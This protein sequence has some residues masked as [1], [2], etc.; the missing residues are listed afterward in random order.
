MSFPLKNGGNMLLNHGPFVLFS[1]FSLFLV[2][3][4]TFDSRAEIIKNENSNAEIVFEGN[5]ADKKG[6]CFNHLNQ[7]EVTALVRGEN[8]VKWLY[9]WGTRPSKE[10]EA[11]FKKQGILFVPMQWGLS[12]PKS[13]SEL[14][15]YYKNHP[16]CKYLLGYNEPN[17]KTA[18]DGGS[19]ITPERAAAD[20]KNLEDIAREF[21]LEL[22]GPALQY[23]GATLSDGKKYDT[24]SKWMDAFILAYKKKYGREPRYD[25]F[26]LHCY[27]NWAGAQ[28]GY[29]NEHARKYGK[30]I[31]LTEFCAWEYNNG[32]QNESMEKQISSMK[33]KLRD[34]E[35][36]AA[37]FKYAWFMSHG[38][39][40]SIPFNSIFEAGNSTKDGDGT[41]TELGKEYIGHNQ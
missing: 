8:S 38:N 17:L 39:A 41:L 24:P 35:A 34:L 12:S 7:A 14:R 15:E 19:E 22:V 21:N 20:W 29:I 31:W 4:C 23:S 11:L 13:L 30:R 2:S 33:E 9:N 18:G 25:Y 1:I 28:A 26:A 16:E 32:G 36:N 6:L 3:S 27:M 40:A 37:V 5:P 10:E